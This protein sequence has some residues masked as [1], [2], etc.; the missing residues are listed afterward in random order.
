MGKR[1]ALV[2][3]AIVIST[4]AL[5]GSTSSKTGLEA[6]A[7][8][9]EINTKAL[10]VKTSIIS[11][12]VEAKAVIAPIAS[13][14]T[15][16]VWATAYSSEIGQTDDTPFV[17]ASGSKVRDG[18]VAAN[19]LPFGTK[20]RIPKLYGDKVFTI[21]DRMNSRYN[22]QKIIDVWFGDTESAIHFGK[23]YTSI[24]LVS[25][26]SKDKMLAAK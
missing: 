21:E 13:V 5:Y 10:T 23:K 4:S 6:Q 11:D 19:F 15:V 16:K 24:E 22:D 7:Q 8:A 20:I 12:S 18:V 17:T 9:Q 14:E 3:I 1:I 2:V 26:P 25:V